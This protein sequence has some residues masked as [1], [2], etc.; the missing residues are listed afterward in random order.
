MIF[1]LIL[2]VGTSGGVLDLAD[3]DTRAQCVGALEELVRSEGYVSLGFGAE[4]KV[5]SPLNE[6]ASNFIYSCVPSPRN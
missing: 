5:T 1:K 2:V 4:G 6:S 3:F